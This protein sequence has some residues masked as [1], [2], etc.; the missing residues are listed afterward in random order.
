MDAALFEFEVVELVGFGAWAS[1]I[2]PV[3]KLMTLVIVIQ[4][5]IPNL[6]SFI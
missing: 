6:K 4:K 1:M 3:K 5:R 2:Q